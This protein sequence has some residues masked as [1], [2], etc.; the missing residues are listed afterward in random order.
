MRDFG[1]CPRRLG[2]L[3]VPHN[4]YSSVPLHRER[5]PTWEM[6]SRA[7]V[8]DMR[9]P[10][11]CEQLCQDW[12]LPRPLVTKLPAAAGMHIAHMLYPS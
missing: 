5:P 2:V 7:L 9:R 3:L 10:A 6:A 4:V 11:P 1:V 8:R 12:L